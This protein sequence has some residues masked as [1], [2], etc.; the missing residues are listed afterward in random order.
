MSHFSTG[1][2]RPQIKPP[3]LRT[4]G[5]G[6]TLTPMSLSPDDALCA[7]AAM[8]HGVV[9]IAQARAAGVPDESIRTR[10]R[11]GEYRRLQRGVL[12]IDAQLYPEVPWMT[13]AFAS[14]LRHGPQAVIGVG[15]AT[16]RLGIAGA[17]TDERI[18]DVVLPPGTERH[19]VPGIALHFWPLSPDEVMELG[20]LRVTTA[21]RTLAD[22]ALHVPRNCAVSAMDSALHQNLVTP[23]ELQLA[24]ALTR[25]RPLCR[26]A[27][28]WWDLAD[29]RSESPLETWSRL[30]CI[31]GGVAPDDLQW[32]VLA[33]DGRFLGRADMAWKKRRRALVAEADGAG[34]HSQPDALFEDRRR[35]NDFVAANVDIV[36]FTWRDARLRGCCAAIVRGAL[37]SEDR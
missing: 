9:S 24:K 13:R 29:G 28:E 22:L 3:M 27:D 15:S 19:Q 36:R 7:R 35:A 8:Q 4:P 30:D 18:I 34:P 12:L 16:R 10:V 37:R 25:G 14:Q 21:T 26:K 33:H 11:R 31:D 17:D 20:G 2:R 5:F 6:S 32:N 23:D 1:A